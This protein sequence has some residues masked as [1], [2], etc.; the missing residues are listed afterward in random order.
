[1]RRLDYSGIYELFVPGVKI[2]DIYKFEIKTR[3]CNIL[4]KAD[5]Y[6]NQAELRPNT[7][8]RVANLYNYWDDQ[9][10]MLN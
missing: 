5:P 2:W 1:M 4:I 3:E 7:A 6:A 10:W 9:E 8:S